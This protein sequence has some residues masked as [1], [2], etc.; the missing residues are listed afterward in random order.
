MMENVKNWYIYM[1][2]FY[3]VIHTL[4]ES[5]SINYTNINE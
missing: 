5:L 1:L 4:L 3:I 2:G